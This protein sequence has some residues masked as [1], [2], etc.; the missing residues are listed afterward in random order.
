MAKPHPS[1]RLYIL[2]NDTI[3]SKLKH[4]SIPWQHKVIVISCNGTNTEIQ[5]AALLNDFHKL[6]CNV[7][8]PATKSLEY[9]T[10]TVLMLIEGSSESHTHSVCGNYNE[11]DVSLLH[12]YL[13]GRKQYNAQIGHLLSQILSNY[14]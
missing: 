1:F 4:H 3:L 8:Y 10:K 2:L 9:A 14:R 6:H 11:L 13:S 5:A 12:S 7:S